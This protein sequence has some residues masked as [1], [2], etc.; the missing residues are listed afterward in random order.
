MEIEKK[1]FNR[2]KVYLEDRALARATV[3]PIQTLNNEIDNLFKQHVKKAYGEGNC[4][5]YSMFAFLNLDDYDK[6]F[7]F[8]KENKEDCINF[9]SNCFNYF[10]KS[11]QDS[12]SILLVL[13]LRY[14]HYKIFQTHKE[15][16]I[17]VQIEYESLA[18]ISLIDTIEKQIIELNSIEFSPISFIPW[19]I[20]LG[21]M[22]FL[23]S[24][25]QAN[26]NSCCSYQFLEIQNSNWCL[27]NSFEYKESKNANFFNDANVQK[28]NK[29]KQNDDKRMLFIA[30]KI[31]SKIEILKKANIPFTFFLQGNHYEPLFF[32]SDAFKQDE[33]FKK[34][35][36]YDEFFKD[37][38]EIIPTKQSI[39]KKINEL[40]CAK[41]ENFSD[42]EVVPEFDS[43]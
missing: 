29:I 22:F 3:N 24:K 9:I 41:T 23:F 11:S 27:I 19:A 28:F 6:I 14:Y 4:F 30:N 37:I 32:E 13:L 12:P 5:Y 42:D 38:K 34:M 20:E 43:I 15:T 25:E 16:L 31:K 8:C 26:A 36:K 33:L 35:N 10:G 18:D 1:E 17:N 21:K 39:I 2:T 7:N 40:K